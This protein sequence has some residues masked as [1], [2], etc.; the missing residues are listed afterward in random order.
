MDILAALQALRGVTVLEALASGTITRDAIAML[1]FKDARAWEKLS[2]VYYGPTR[3]RRLQTAAREAAAE[4]SLDA[5][6]VIEKHTRTLLRGAPLSEWEL[7]AELCGLRGTVDEISHHAAARVRDLN[8]TVTDADQKAYG[9]RALRGGKNTN[10]LGLRTFST[11]LMERDMTTVMGHLIPTARALRKQDPKL[12]FVQA[13]AD[14]LVRHVTGVVGDGEPLPVVTQVVVELEDYITILRGDGD[15]IILGLTDG[16]TMTGAQWLNEHLAERHLVGLYHPVEG[17]VD[18]YRSERFASY[19]QRMLLAAATLIC[20]YPGCTTAAD[21]CQVHHLT[22]WEQGGN[23]NLS[24]LTVLC[25]VHNA[26]NDDDPAKPP[27]NG[28][29]ERRPGG[30]VHI[31]PDGGPPRTNTH[32]IRKYSA[33]GLINA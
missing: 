33:M 23:T 21:Q 19:K 7:R 31:P 13:M 12:T 10:G 1:G 5:L 15:D 26:R 24:E 16:T 20:P 28:R 30:V 6:M 18:L 14:A 32:P 22:A 17:P 29:M 11:T 27:R 3:H 9:K 8:R 4:L 2:R 25:Q